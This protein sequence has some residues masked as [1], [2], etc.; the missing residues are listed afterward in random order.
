M[1]ALYYKQQILESK[2]NV[3]FSSSTAFIVGKILSHI[4]EKSVRDP[5][6]QGFVSFI[7]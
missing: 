2:T 6:S 3:T 5:N 4:N 1:L 7:H